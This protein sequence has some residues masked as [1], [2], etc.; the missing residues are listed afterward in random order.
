MKNVAAA[1][2]SLIGRECFFP[3]EERG[4]NMLSPL[5]VMTLLYGGD[6]VVHY[7]DEVGDEVGFGA[8]EEEGE[9]AMGFSIAFHGAGG[10]EDAVA[11]ERSARAEAAVEFVEISFGPAAKGFG[12]RVDDFF[13]ERIGAAIEEAVEEQRRIL[14]QFVGAHAEAGGEA[15]ERAGV[16]SIDA[17]EN[18]FDG[19]LVETRARDDVAEGETLAS[20]EAAEVRG[21]VAHCVRWFGGRF[22]EFD[23]DRVLDVIIYL[24][25]LSAVLS[26]GSR[27]EDRG[28]RVE[29][30]GLRV[31]G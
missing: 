4:D 11:A 7:V 30:R 18:S 10:G 31:E 23:D 24:C 29:D 2:C 26:S 16:R 19:S 27:I 6:A 5:D 1:D 3:S 21:V 13:D 22:R 12:I 15:I 14:K 9:L 17:G 20:H 28:L 25:I 8:F